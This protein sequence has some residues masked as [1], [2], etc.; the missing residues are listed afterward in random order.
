MSEVRTIV[1]SLEEAEELGMDISHEPTRAAGL[2]PQRCP[3]P[4]PAPDVSV[5]INRDFDAAQL[6]LHRVLYG[7][8]GAGAARNRPEGSVTAA[9]VEVT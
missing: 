7:A 2:Q 4:V 1:R 9:L 3:D 5:W 8:R 6:A